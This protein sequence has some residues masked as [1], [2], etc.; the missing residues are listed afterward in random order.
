M[1]WCAP[2]KQ[3]R[4]LC[5]VWSCVLCGFLCLALMI[6]KRTTFCLTFCQC[7]LIFFERLLMQPEH[8]PEVAPT[9]QVTQSW[10]NKQF[11]LDHLCSG[12]LTASA[13]PSTITP[14]SGSILHLPWKHQ[15][16]TTGLHQ[17]C[18]LF[19]PGR[20]WLLRRLCQWVHYYESWDSRSV[21]LVLS[22]VET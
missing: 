1:K 5:F 12:P 22:T 16:Q 3:Q 7:S 8:S 11:L 10:P 6:L 20:T 21:C 2:K 4:Q 19:C 14:S 13:V 17:L 15:L 18:P 9:F